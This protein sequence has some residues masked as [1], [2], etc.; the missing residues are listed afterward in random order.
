MSE[1]E[2]AR[3]GVSVEGQRAG[4]WKLGPHSRREGA[5]KKKK[6]EGGKMVLTPPPGLQRVIVLI[7]GRPP[8]HI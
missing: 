4:Q 5:D 2:A 8:R 1:C 7:M 3:R 6:T